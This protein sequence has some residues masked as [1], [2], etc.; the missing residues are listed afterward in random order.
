MVIE[1]FGVSVREVTVLLKHSMRGSAPSVH[2]SSCRFAVNVASHEIVV[3]PR[4]RWRMRVPV[5]PQ[6]IER[7]KYCVNSIM[8]PIFIGGTLRRTYAVN[9]VIKASPLRCQCRIHPSH[10][11]NLRQETPHRAHIGGTSA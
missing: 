4:P 6:L 1:L 2:K 9:T 8:H 5:L 11:A 7:M 3:S 10:T